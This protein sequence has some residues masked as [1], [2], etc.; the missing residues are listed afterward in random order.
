MDD[1]GTLDGHSDSE[2]E[3]IN[4]DGEI[5]GKSYGRSSGGGF[6]YTDEFG[7]LELDALIDNL[8]AN[9]RSITAGGRFQINDS[10]AIC[11][12]VRLDDFSVQAFVLIP[13]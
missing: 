7:M 5:V 4:S 12:S 3:G 6:L 10:G 13:N 11:S 9:Y 8:P 2:A 1:L